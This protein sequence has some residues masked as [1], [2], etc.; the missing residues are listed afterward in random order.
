MSSSVAKR[1]RQYQYDF[2][3]RDASFTELWTLYPNGE[4]KNVMVVF[5]GYPLSD[6]RMAMQ[7]E[8]IGQFEDEPSNLR[9]TEALLHT[10]VIIT[11]FRVDGPPLYQNPAAR[12]A[13]ES[14]LADFASLVVNSKEYVDMMEKVTQAGEDRRVSRLQTAKGTRWFDLSLKLCSDAVT[15]EPALLVTA[16]DVTEL[17]EARDTA[18]YLADRDQLTN[19]YNRTYL[20]NHL[21]ELEER[22]PSGQCAIIFFDVDRFKLINDRYGHL[23][24]IHIS[25]PTRPY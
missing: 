17:K 7:C 15:A 1:L 24:L 2:Q 21:S 4:P 11:L 8:A 13:F 14:P 23:S 9:S 25:E 12:N 6:G 19:L 5:R 18:R 3:D 10:D 16:I 22:A 20:Q